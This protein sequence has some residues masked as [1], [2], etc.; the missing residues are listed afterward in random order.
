MPG[1]KLLGWVSFCMLARQLERGECVLK[2][3]GGG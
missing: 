3:E 2:Q 1:F